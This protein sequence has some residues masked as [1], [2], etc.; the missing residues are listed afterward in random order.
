MVKD[1]L[2]FCC[3]EIFQGE[4]FPP[5]PSFIHSIDKKLNSKYNAFSM[6]TKL[7]RNLKIKFTFGYL[8]SRRRPTYKTTNNRI[9][10][11]STVTI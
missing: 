2:G 4:D 8:N 3:T 10:I 9:Q 7:D 6:Q 5:H 11:A 1:I